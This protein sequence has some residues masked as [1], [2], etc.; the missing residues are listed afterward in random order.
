LSEEN[1]ELPGGPLA[2]RP[3]DFIWILDCSGSMNVQGKM[4]EL[5][6]AIKEALPAMQEAAA[7]NPQARLLVRALTFSDGARW[8]VAQ[9]TP[10]DQFRWEPVSAGGVT[11]LGKALEMVAEQLRMPPMEQR[12]LPPVLVL[13]S[14]GQPTDDFDKG[15]KTLMAESWAKKAVRISIAIGEDADDE[16]L[17]RFVGNPELPVL[18]ANNAPTLRKFI[19]WVSTKV[20]QSA[21]APPSERIETSGDSAPNVSNVPIPRVPDAVES[22]DDVW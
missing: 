10:V 20:V 1:L 18:R 22:A 13:V 12:A 21:S 14:D 17:R 5:N 7:D 2:A 19:R 9:R 3:L 16:P 11:D 4:S 8:H 6:F 15:L